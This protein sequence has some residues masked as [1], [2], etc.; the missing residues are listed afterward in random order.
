MS[1]RDISHPQIV[2]TRRAARR[3][4]DRELR[5]SAARG[6]ISR[7][8]RGAYL[9]IPAGRRLGDGDRFDAAIEAVVGTRWSDVVL[10]AQSA[11]RVWGLP[12]LGRWPSTVDLIEPPA[13]GRRSRNGVVIRRRGWVAEHT[14][15]RGGLLV[16]SLAET[17]AEIACRGSRLD[18]L[19]VLDAAL[20]LRR[21]RVTRDEVLARILERTAQNGRRRGEKALD[22]ADG[23]SQSPLETW[24]R[25]LI[26]V[27]GFEPPE[28][29]RRFAVPSGDRFAD[30][31][32]K[33]L[34][35]VGEVDG[36]TKYDEFARADSLDPA[37]VVW[38]EKLRELEL[39]DHGVSIARWTVADLREPSRLVLRLRTVGLHPR[40]RGLRALPD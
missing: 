36:R 32:W 18:A 7:V 34:R 27:L 1:D 21:P 29:Q 9:E 38:R 30:F 28:L 37:D 24:S 16:T 23:A 15:E 35:V 19:I 8:R 14:V 6:E 13:S 11:A 12:R 20:D 40:R 31:W 2:L 26:D 4:A 25:D 17:L 3:G 22:F 39:R 10:G 33:R 5:R